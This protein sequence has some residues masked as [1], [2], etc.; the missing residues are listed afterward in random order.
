VRLSSSF[1]YKNMDKGLA[2]FA[3]LCTA[4]GAFLSALDHTAGT[5]IAYDLAY[6]LGLP[7]WFGSLFILMVAMVNFPRI[8]LFI[9][10]YIALDITYGRVSLGF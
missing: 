4:T 9:I 2:G 3:L 5:A 7:L 1:T 8:H 10:N 6:D